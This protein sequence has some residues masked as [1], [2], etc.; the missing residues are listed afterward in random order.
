MSETKKFFKSAFSVDNVIF[1]FD[2]GTLKVLL[3]KRA[4]QPYIGQWALPGDLVYPN[5]DLE[6]AAGRVLA[7]LTGLKNVYLEQV[8]TFGKVDRHPLGRVITIAYYSLIKI[9]NFEFK[10]DSFASQVVWHDVAKIEEL[11]FD[12]QLILD[13]CFQ[14]LKW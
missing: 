9:D 12:H 14:K 1:G 2:Q 3:I 4:A 7:E 5:E 13:T 10:P 6:S 8:H 11:A